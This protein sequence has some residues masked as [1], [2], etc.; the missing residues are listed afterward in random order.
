MIKNVIYTFLSVVVTVGSTALPTEAQVINGLQIISPLDGTEVVEGE[1]ITVQVGT[2]PTVLSF[3]LVGLQTNGLVTSPVT[4]P[5]GVGPFI[6]TVVAPTSVAGF[7]LTAV[8][9]PQAQV[10]TSLQS[11]PIRLSVVP[12]LAVT[13]LSCQLSKNVLRFP[14]DRRRF[15]ILGTL[16][17]GT[18]TLLSASQRLSFSA[19]ASGVASVDSSG[20]VLGVGAGTAIIIPS[21][22]NVS[23][24][25]ISGSCSVDVPAL[26]VGDLDGNG[27]VDLDD[28]AILQSYLNQP[29]TGPSD[30]R[31]LNHDGKI[32]ALDLRLMTNLCT[33]PRCAVQ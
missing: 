16:S 4:L 33:R 17:D 3:Q 32:D 31:D 26:A 19:D 25:V 22:R 5:S 23:G 20:V 27:T 18:S 6:F 1:S 11:A 28:V 8:G 2:T 15:T 9:V 21:Y 12:R 14:G 29:S 10:A 7:L 30:A 24:A 13:S